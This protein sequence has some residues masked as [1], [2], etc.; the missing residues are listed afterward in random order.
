M[1]DLALIVSLMLLGELLIGLA[2]ITFAIIYRVKRKFAKTT[3]VLIGL[4]TLE[5]VWALSLLPAFG[6][7]PLV[8]LLISAALRFIPLKK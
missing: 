4:L 2:V 5:T 7:P 6:F 1:E 8:A 3:L